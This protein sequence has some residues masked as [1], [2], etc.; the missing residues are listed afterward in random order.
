MRIKDIM[1]AG[2]IRAELITLQEG[3]TSTLNGNE[4]ILDRTMCLAFELCQLIEGD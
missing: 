3:D 2:E 1:R 4:T